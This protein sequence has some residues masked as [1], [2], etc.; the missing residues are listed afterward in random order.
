[1]ADSLSSSFIRPEKFWRTVGLKANQVVV[2]LGCGAGYF[3]VP[4]AKQVGPGGRAIGVDI[5]PDMLA[6][7]EARAKLEGVTETVQTL[8]AD[9]EQAAPRGLPQ[10][11][12]DW[13][14]MVNIHYQA[15]PAPIFAQAQ[16]VVKYSGKVAAVWWDIAATP[17]GPPHDRRFTQDEIK[18]FAHQAGLTFM[19]A[20]SVSP[21]HDAL[22][23]TLLSPESEK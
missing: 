15:E 11:A 6:E 23:F 2:H 21:Y 14:L 7:T 12:A 18:H 10:H 19:K 13:V 20:V 5:R 8:R 9:L 22:I 3:I 4:A 17:L 1:M 16:K